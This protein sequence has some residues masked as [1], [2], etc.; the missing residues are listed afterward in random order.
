MLSLGC[1]LLAG[2]GQS[3]SE[4]AGNAASASPPPV[5]AEV[6]LAELEQHPSLHRSFLNQLSLRIQNG[7]V[8]IRYNSIQIARKSEG[9]GGLNILRA[10]GS[11]RNKM[12]TVLRLTSE[13]E[14][15][16]DVNVINEADQ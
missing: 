4:E 10:Q 14:G 6:I 15:V 12:R 13:I 11:I 3:G 2:C 5:T 7:Y 16:K 1:V 8:E 9:D